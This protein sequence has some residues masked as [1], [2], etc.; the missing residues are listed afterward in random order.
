MQLNFFQ[1]IL[2][3]KTLAR[4]QSRSRFRSWPEKFNFPTFVWNYIFGETIRCRCCFETTKRNRNETNRTFFFLAEQKKS[5]TNLSEVAKGWESESTSEDFF[6]FVPIFFSLWQNKNKKE[7]KLQKRG[8]C[9]DW[10]F[11]VSYGNLRKV[12]RRKINMKR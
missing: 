1:I 12:D 5:G 10:V 6:Y 4:S 3:K 8:K 9:R 2:W 11:G 7:N